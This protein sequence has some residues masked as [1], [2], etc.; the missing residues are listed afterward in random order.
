MDLDYSLPV[1]SGLDIQPIDGRRLQLRFSYHPDTVARIKEI[2]GRRWHPDDKYWSVPHR[3]ESLAALQRLFGARPIQTFTRPARRP[4]AVTKRR[5][6]ALSDEERA[7]IAAVEE[8]E[9]RLRAYSSKTRKSYRNHLVRFYRHF[10]GRVLAEL[11]EKEVRTYLLKLVEEPVSR[12]YLNQA[13]SAIKLLYEKVIRQPKII[14]QIPRPRGERKLPTVIS[15]EAAQNLLNAVGNLKHQTLLVLMYA[16]GLRVGEVVRLQMEDIDS[17]RKLIRVR[18]GKGRKDRYTLYSD[19]ASE[20][21]RTYMKEY[22]PIEWL[23]EGP[24]PGAHITERTVQKVVQRARRQAGIPQHVTTH[25]L[26]HSFATHLLDYHIQPLLGHTTV[27]T[28]AGYLPLPPRALA[29]VI[30]PLDRWASF[31]LRPLAGGDSHEIFG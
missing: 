27:K 16:A 11:T 7:F 3:P 1:I 15:R 5:W 31:E 18:G 22:Q 24:K 23:F 17:E 30:S 26:R 10:T 28:T 9:M 8:E 21:V 20:M 12:S 4:G 6:A 29:Q 14:E 13:I 25:T 2:P 19:L